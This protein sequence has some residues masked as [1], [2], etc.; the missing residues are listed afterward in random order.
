[1]N[2][3][4]LV[5]EMRR[6][7]LLPCL[8]ALGAAAALAQPRAP[9]RGPNAAV[10][11]ALTFC[12]PGHPFD[13]CD[14]ALT[15]GL[16]P[17]VEGAPEGPGRRVVALHAPWRAVTALGAEGRPDRTRELRFEGSLPAGAARRRLLRTF[18]TALRT[19]TRGDEG[20]GASGCIGVGV[21]WYDDAAARTARTPRVQ[22]TVEPIASPPMLGG[23]GERAFVA[24]RGPDQTVRLCVFGPPIVGDDDPVQQALLAWLTG[25]DF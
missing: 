2:S 3:V 23:P 24:S 5:T 20:G 13:E 4:V 19:M 9:A 10:G 15:L 14:A 16:A 6:L 11:S 18:D 7:A 12:L 1:M 21:A 17:H 25:P 8:L 22:L